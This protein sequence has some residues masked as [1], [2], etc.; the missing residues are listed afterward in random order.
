[1]A[2]CGVLLLTI[3]MVYKY[4]VGFGLNYRLSFQCGLGPGGYRGSQEEFEYV[5]GR[6]VLCV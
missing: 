4:V 6:F 5:F 1:M 2:L 3:A